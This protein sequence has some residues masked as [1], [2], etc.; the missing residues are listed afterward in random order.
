MLHLITW[1]TYAYFNHISSHSK[2]FMHFELFCIAFVSTSSITAWNTYKILGCGAY[3]AFHCITENQCYSRALHT[4]WVLTYPYNVNKWIPI[5][6]RVTLT[7]YAHLECNAFD[8]W[9]NLSYFHI[10]ITFYSH[11]I[12]NSLS[13][14]SRFTD[15]F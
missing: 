13:A 5:N 15:A 8:N 9:H 2:K 3:K 7:G 12:E 6:L 14:R 4:K 10:I 1:Q 11:F